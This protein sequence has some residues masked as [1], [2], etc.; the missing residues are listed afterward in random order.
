MTFA[1]PI[2]RWQE[3][4]GE[5]HRIRIERNRPVGEVD[6]HDHDFMEL[7]MVVRGTAMHDSPAGKW[8]LTSGDAMLLRPG[9]WHIYRECDDLEVINFC[10]PPSFA[11]AEWQ[12][13]LDERVRTLLR[14]G[15][16]IQSTRFAEDVVLV[17]DTME[18]LDKEAMGA[19]GFLIWT[20]DQFATSVSVQTRKLHPAVEMAVA[21]MEE[22]PAFAWSAT[23][24]SQEVALDKAYLSRLFKDQ[25]GVAPM[26]YLAQLR[27]ERA[28]FLLR[29]SEMNC[30]EVGEAAGYASLELFSKRF[31]ARYGVSPS[32]YR[33]T[34]QCVKVFSPPDHG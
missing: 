13:L 10:F 33:K 14:L 17:L 32:A 12:D 20:L 28:A 7:V 16:G 18:R 31:R 15:S 27:A 1:H 2:L 6:A 21:A 23:A 34:P 30:T 4:F 3:L 24:L 26:A 25:V 5:S 22:R 11:R 19:L 8:P 9:T 29:H